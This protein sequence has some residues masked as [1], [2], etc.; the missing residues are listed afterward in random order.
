MLLVAEKTA[1]AFLDRWFVVARERL[2]IT[3]V[4][5]KQHKRRGW[6]RECCLDVEDAVAIFVGR[7]RPLI[8]GHGHGDFVK[9]VAVGRAFA[10]F[11]RGPLHEH[12]KFEERALCA[13]PC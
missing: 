7:G 13:N 10:L 11:A 1:N 4:D 5:N 3:M 6:S 12:R 9:R 8:R 2:S